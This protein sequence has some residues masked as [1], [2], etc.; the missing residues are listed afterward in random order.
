[1]PSDDADDAAAD[2]ENGSENAMDYE[3]NFLE[4]FFK[5]QAE[6]TIEAIRTKIR[7]SKDEKEIN[8]LLQQIKQTEDE[9]ALNLEVSRSTP[10]KDA[11]GSLD[12]KKGALVLHHDNAAF[13]QHKEYRIP[14]ELW[15]YL[16]PYQQQ[17]VKW[18]LDLHSEG[19]GGILADEMGL[20]KTI[21]AIAYLSALFASSSAIQA[22]VLVPATIVDEWRRQLRSALPP[23]VAVLAKPSRDPGVVVASYDQF[24]LWGFGIFTDTVILD[25]GHKIKNK[26]AQVTQHVKEIRAA[27]RFILTGTPIQ[28]NLTELWSLFDFVYPRLLGTHEVFKE[29][30]EENIKKKEDKEVSYKYS[31]MLRSVVEPYIL[32]RYKSQI[33]HAL[34]GKVDKVVFISLSPVQHKMYVSALESDEIRDAFLGRRNMLGAIDHLRKIC[35]HPSL[36]SKLRLHAWRG[37]KE[38]QGISDYADSDEDAGSGSLISSSCKMVV[39]FDLLRKWK[40]ENCKVLVFTQTVQMQK[41]IAR[42]LAGSYRYLIMS[43]A[44]PVARRSSLVREFNESES[45]SVFLLTTRVGGLGLNLT[46]ASRIVLYDPDWNPSTDNQ[47]KERIHRYGQTE[48]VEIYR[49]V[50]RNTIEEKVY[51]KQIYKECLGRKILLDPRAVISGESMMDIFSYSEVCDTSYTVKDYQPEGK[52]EEDALVDVREE[53]KREFNTMKTYNAKAFLT[54]HE[55]IDYIERRE[56]GFGP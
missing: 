27:S 34:P 4:K 40:K 15:D 45:I 55:L 54:G 18:M 9:L 31:V 35:N 29:E 23:G 44:T 2:V 36:A 51:Q 49:L 14:Q 53:D 56:A 26:D 19:R 5:A 13:Y 38:D 47:A 1:M 48:N 37:I 39:L 16:F 30:F 25:E 12:K 8:K 17:G 7:A 22:L 41:I 52:K 33:S 42:S 10:A 32:R 3:K 11:L 50:C 24:K 43:G 21:Q 28:N 20:G 6:R 46:G